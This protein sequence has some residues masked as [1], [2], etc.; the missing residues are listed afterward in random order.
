M[1]REEDWIREAVDR[2]SGPLTRYACRIVGDIERAR[3]VVQDTFIKLCKVKEAD[4]SGQVGAWLYTVCRNRALDML[5]KEARLDHPGNDAFDSLPD[6]A[7]GPLGV[8]ERRQTANRTLQVLDTLPE[9]Q[10]EVIRLKFQEE[11]SYRE[12]SRIT[13]LSISNVGFLIHVGI[14]TIRE[15]LKEGQC[16][17]K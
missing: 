7:P 17:E 8:V 1:P 12:I 2:Y 13:G 15:R 5:R 14:K 9:N 6:P 11:M 10:Q 3:D 4:V 16:H